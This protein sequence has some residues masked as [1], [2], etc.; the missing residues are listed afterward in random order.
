MKTFADLVR[1]SIQQY[2]DDCMS[3]YDKISKSEE[4]IVEIDVLPEAPETVYVMRL[5]AAD[6]VT[7]MVATFY[8]KEKI[9]L[10]P[11]ENQQS[12]FTQ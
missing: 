7:D 9:V 12:S 1:G 5:F 2:G 3:I 8:N 11:E 4:E 10:L 6:W